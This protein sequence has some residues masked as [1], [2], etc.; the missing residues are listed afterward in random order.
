MLQIRDDK[1]CYA[2]GGQDGLAMTE[3][4]CHAFSFSKMQNHLR[5]MCRYRDR[6][7][8]R[9]K[10]KIVYSHCL[11]IRFRRRSG[12]GVKL[13]FFLYDSKTI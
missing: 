12:D 10:L 7:L 8:R 6:H 3:N 4:V 5:K 9:F 13:N 1:R 11:S 2:I